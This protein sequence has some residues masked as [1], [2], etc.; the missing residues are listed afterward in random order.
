MTSIMYNS[1]E[2]KHFTRNNKNKN[3]TSMHN[4]LAY[5][6]RV[7]W[8][9]EE[10]LYHLFLWTFILTHVSSSPGLVSGEDTREN[11]LSPDGANVTCHPPCLITQFCDTSNNKVILNVTDTQNNVTRTALGICKPCSAICLNDN[12][13]QNTQ[14]L[15]ELCSKVCP[16]KYV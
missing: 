15:S 9:A 4:G 7:K 2:M 14:D 8:K 13:T 5:Y 16:G 10:Y 12:N 1:Y 3:N 6:K 11:V